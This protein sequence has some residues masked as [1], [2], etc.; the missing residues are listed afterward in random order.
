MPY[1]IGIPYLQTMTKFGV[2]LLAHSH[3]F[4][5]PWTVAC[6]APLFMGFARQE[7][8]S[9]VPFPSPGDLPDP[10]LLHWQAVSL[11][12]SQQESTLGDSGGQKSL[13]ATAHGVARGQTW[14][15][16]WTATTVTEL[17]NWSLR[18]QNASIRSHH[19]MSLGG[20]CLHQCAQVHRHKSGLQ[21]Y[22]SRLF[23]ADG[24]NQCNAVKTTNSGGNQLR[25]WPNHHHCAD[26][27]A[28][29]V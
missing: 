7:Y 20:L 25:A 13:Q 1:A 2:K 8:W 17:L 6:Q 23:T 10:G 24:L 21:K 18:F 28:S 26:F 16:S 9:G 15:R 12:L 4:A 19:N 3:S 14:P 29:P 5:I 11:P 22:F 27:L